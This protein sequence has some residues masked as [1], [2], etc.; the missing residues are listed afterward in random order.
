[1]QAIRSKLTGENIVDVREEDLIYFRNLTHLDL[2]DNNVNLNQLKN[3]SGLMELDLQYNNIE[4]LQVTHGFFARLQSLK[5]SYNRVPPSHL[6]ELGKMPRLTTLEIA[7]NDLSTLPANLSFLTQLQELNL[8]S[9]N[10]ASD[11]IMVSVSDLF[12]SMG[13]MPQLRVLNLSR[14]KFKGFH[15]DTLLPLLNQETGEVTEIDYFPC[16]QHL[17]L[18]FNLIDNQHEL[19]Y[20]VFLCTGQ[21]KTGHIRQYPFKS[22]N[23]TGNP[24]AYEPEAYQELEAA[25]QQRGAQLINEPLYGSGAVGLHRVKRLGLGGIASKPPLIAIQNNGQDEK[26]LFGAIDND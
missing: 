24:L 2:S 20:A 6:A 4:Y 25:L 10:F 16:L 17:N 7:A 22:L 14:N 23:I 3:L 11:S 19:E 15:S 26:E 1:M 8:S 9:N 21:T 18:S 5:L 12:K 13:L